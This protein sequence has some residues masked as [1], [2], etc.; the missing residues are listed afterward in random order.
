VAYGTNMQ[1][2]QTTIFYSILASELGHVFCC[3][4]PTVLSILTLAAS[5]GMVVTIPGFA[6]S[7]HNYIHTWE[8]LII[9]ISAALL[10]LGWSLFA[11]NARLQIKH[12]CCSQ[13]TCNKTRHKSKII[14]I[15]ATVLFLVN[16]SAYFLLHKDRN[17]VPVAPAQNHHNHANA[18]ISE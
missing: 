10:V 16:V 9:A 14:M 1:K 5:Y 13:T 18:V 2:L 6:L 15:I 8:H 11:L 4:I 17:T 12:D 7:Y 3:V